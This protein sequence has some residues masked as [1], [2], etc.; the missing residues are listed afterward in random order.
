MES[1]SSAQ[2]D[3]VEQVK[4]AFEADD[5]DRVRT[6]IDDHPELRAKIN[7]PWGP[8]D[9][10]L[11]VNVRSRPMLDVLLDA[12]ADLNAKS[13]WWAG[14][15]GLLDW[16]SPAL[17]DYAIKQGALV[18]VHAAARLGIMDRLQE[19]VAGDPKLVHSR[20]GDGK[21][22]LHFAGSVQIAAYLLDHGAEIDARDIDHESTPAQY[23]ID[24]RQEVVRFLISRGC[25]TDLLMASAL[26]D[27]ELVKK[28]LDVDPDSIRMCVSEE[29]FPK[30]NKQ[31]GGTIYGWTLGFFLSAHQVARKFG[32]E[33][34]VHFLFDRSPEPVK[35]I[36]ACWFGDEV[37]V[38]SIRTKH[39]GTAVS[40]TDSDRRQVA[41]A[42]RKNNTAA[43]RLMLESGLPVDAR[44]QH[45]ATPIHWAAFHGNTEM[46]KIIL[47]YRPPLELRD[48]DFDGTPL[49]WAIHGSENGWN[50]DTGDYA[51][52][53][54]VLI[55]AGRTS[56]GYQGIRSGSKL[57]CAGTARMKSR[58]YNEPLRIFAADRAGDSQNHRAVVR[59]L[60]LVIRFVERVEADEVI[61]YALIA[62]R[63]A[64]P[65]VPT[66]LLDFRVGP[67][68]LRLWRTGD[69]EPRRPVEVDLNVHAMFAPNSTA[70]S[71]SLRTGSLSFLGFARSVQQR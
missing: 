69:R 27:L 48:G 64:R 22:P 19:L 60:E 6:L 13:R 4:K 52:T 24:E 46:T 62:S 37:M 59:R 51:G 57:I 14:G 70:W 31:S 44:G 29:F 42:A 58:H 9:S 36:T 54:D 15:F 40:F 50:S 47:N 8:F 49:D 33:D 30:T 26:G 11:I 63:E 1:A 55:A 25:Q 12:G 67:E 5:A 71:I 7:E 18:D 21:T 45:N 66:D 2:P 3:P 35:L 68:R 28:H 39:A 65:V 34:I 17:A 10:P 41:H 53:A 20:G 56:P 43:V 61:G 38:Q 16:V 32:H 23:M